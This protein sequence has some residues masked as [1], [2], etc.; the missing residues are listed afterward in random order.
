MKPELK[1][2]LVLNLSVFALS[3][4][5]LFVLQLAPVVAD[6]Q[7]LSRPFLLLLWGMANLLFLLTDLVLRKLALWWRIKFRR[8]FSFS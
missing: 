8:W 7:G 5:L 6:F 4:L 2:L 3:S 1:K